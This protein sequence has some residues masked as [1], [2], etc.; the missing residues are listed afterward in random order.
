MMEVLAFCRKWDML[1]RGGRVLCAVSGGRDSM[2]LLCLLK[3]LAAGEGFTLCAAHYN[4][5]LRPTARRDED[6][7]RAFCAENGI[8]L[9]VGRGDVAAFAR[10]TGRSLEDAART[11]RYRFLEE[12]ADELGADRIAT[13]HHRRDNAE[14]VLLHLLRGTGLRGLGGIPPVRGRVVRPLLETDRDEIDAYVNQ[15]HVPFVEDETNLETDYTRNRLRLTVLPLLEEVAPGCTARL[16]ETAGLLREEA[17]HLD[18]ET[19]ALLPPAGENFLS[20]SDLL[21]QDEAVRRR[22]VRAMAGRF[23]VELTARQTGAVLDLQNG[24]HLDLPRG[25][26]VRRRADELTFQKYAPAAAFGAAAGGADLGRLDRP[27][28]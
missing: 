21:R 28:Q 14:T 24:G 20:V 10:E 15:N 11:L 18:R 6:F 16:A 7:V 5:Q 22:M 12:T 19:A 8:S 2:A 9:T 1:P 17:N 3:D 26:T 4:H 13:A 27:G 23:G 25:L